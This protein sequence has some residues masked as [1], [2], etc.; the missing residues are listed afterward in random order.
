MNYKEKR[1]Q[2]GISQ[3]EITRKLEISRTTYCR[4]EKDNHIPK[5]KYRIKV[6]RIL[7]G[8]KT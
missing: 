7:K 5:Y 3:E 4:W 1:L 2:L 8:E 6:E